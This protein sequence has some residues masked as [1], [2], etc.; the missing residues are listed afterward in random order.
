MTHLR[1]AIPAGRVWWLGSA[2]PHRL[3]EVPPLDV[4]KSVLASELSTRSE[5]L[6]RSLARLRDAGHIAVEGKRIRILAPQRLE[7]Q[8]RANLGEAG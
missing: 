8:F 6:S 4:T 3:R 1:G 5:T 2:P 7:A